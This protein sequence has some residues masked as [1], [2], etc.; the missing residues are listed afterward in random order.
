[1]K[2]PKDSL[3]VSTALLIASLFFVMKTI[4]FL[5]NA[6]EAV[7]IVVEIE[8]IYDDGVTFAPVF[9]F[10]DNEGLERTVQSSV[11][12][13][14]ASHD[15]GDEVQ[16]LY[17]PED[18]S[19]AKINNFFNIWGLAIILGGLGVGIIIIAKE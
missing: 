19:K 16:V 10:T 18:S 8:R 7:G 6:H 5:D 13:N 4:S 1:M 9:K 17:D 15:V 3:F 11:S 2:I 12:S 14:P